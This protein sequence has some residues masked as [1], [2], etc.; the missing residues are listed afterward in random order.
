MADPF[1]PTTGV[2]C[3]SE[4]SEISEA[5]G[6]A[7]RA[8]VRGCRRR[9]RRHRKGG[10]GGSKYKQNCYFAPHCSQKGLRRAAMPPPSSSLNAYEQSQACAPSPSQLSLFFTNAF[11]LPPPLVMSKISACLDRA[12][13][14]VL[15]PA[16]VTE[17][18]LQL[19]CDLFENTQ[20]S[21]G[22]PPPSM[23]PPPSAAPFATCRC[24][25]PFL[26][27]RP[28]LQ[29]H[30]AASDAA[31]VA[32]QEHSFPSVPSPFP[33]SCSLSSL[34]SALA[35]V[36]SKL[37][38]VWRTRNLRAMGRVKD[39]NNSTDEEVYVC[40]QSIS[41]GMDNDTIY[42]YKHHDHFNHYNRNKQ[43]NAYP[44]PGLITRLL[45][46]CPPPSHLL[47]ICSFASR[48]EV[49]S[50]SPLHT[51]QQPQTSLNHHLLA[52]NNSK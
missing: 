25:C 35:L 10:G 37:M 28:A 20:A 43:L 18:F 26:F 50:T 33:S 19:K 42:V 14:I 11:Y 40:L 32:V 34:Y 9:R 46:L 5:V 31:A 1:P 48:P 24:F 4:K 52:Q 7:A 3:Q 30:A 17:I 51:T 47:F 21:T 16:D 22:K 12:G 36:H 29:Y 41:S 45:S 49:C 2:Y 27:T 38:F 44:L 39:Y 23:L 15:G 6:R 8:C 13:G